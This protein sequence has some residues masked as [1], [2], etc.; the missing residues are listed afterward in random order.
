MQD[1][2]AA[3]CG[4]DALKDEARQLAAEACPVLITGETGVGK[5]L[6]AAAIHQASPRRAVVSGRVRPG[7]RTT[8][9]AGRR[10]WTVPSPWR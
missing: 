9:R 4:L 8:R 3:I 5:N 7:G 10:P 2:F 1:P 6:F